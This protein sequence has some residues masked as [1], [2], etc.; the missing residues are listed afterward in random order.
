MTYTE[1]YREH[2]ECTFN[3]DIENRLKSQLME[4]ILKF[5]FDS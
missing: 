4:A 3:D 2:I 1:Q 5:R